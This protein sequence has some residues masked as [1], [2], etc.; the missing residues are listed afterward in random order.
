MPGDRREH[1]RAADVGSYYGRRSLGCIF[2]LSRAAQVFGFAVG[3]L[4]AAVVFDSA[5]SYRGAFIGLAVVAI[6]ASLL[7]ATA[8]RPAK[9]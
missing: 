5:G 3:P 9:I 7:L 4:A 1:S 6:M 2:G 8:R